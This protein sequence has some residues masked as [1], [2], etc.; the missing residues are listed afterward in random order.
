MTADEV[1]GNYAARIGRMTSAI[2]HMQS[3]ELAAYEIARRSPGSAAK[4]PESAT[5]L[6]CRLESFGELRRDCRWAELA[7]A[8]SQLERDIN[9]TIG[10][11]QLVLRRIE[12]QMR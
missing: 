1:S 7:A 12:E 2:G 3:A 4:V 11:L 10:R 5:G 8:M 6:R 9:Q